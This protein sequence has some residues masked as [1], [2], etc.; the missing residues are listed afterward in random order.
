LGEQDGH[1][2]HPQRSCKRLLRV[3]FDTTTNTREARWS[4][5]PGKG[6]LC[7]NSNGSVLGANVLDL[8]DGRLVPHWG[9]L[10]VET[11]VAG[12][13]LGECL[14]DHSG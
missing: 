10:S 9:K 2:I 1:P 13:W 12:R 8:A 3:T 14:F 4:I 6:G 7:I 5:I 11:G